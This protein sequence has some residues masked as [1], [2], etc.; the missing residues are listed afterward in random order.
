DCTQIL[1]ASEDGTLKFW[2][3]KTASNIASWEVAKLNATTKLQGPDLAKYSPDG[4]YILTIMSQTVRVWETSTGKMVSEMKGHQ[5]RIRTAEFSPTGK[6]VVTGAED[7][8][9]TAR[10]WDTQTGQQLAWSDHQG[11]VDAAF[12]P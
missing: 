2:D 9:R 1:T 12:S 7:R 6:L 11:G 4:K 8:D 10:L 5:D 3:T